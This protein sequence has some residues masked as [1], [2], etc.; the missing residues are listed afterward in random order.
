L[1]KKLRTKL[2]IHVDSSFVGVMSNGTSGDVTNQNFELPNPSLNLYQ[3]SAFVSED[4]ATRIV[5]VYNT[6]DF[7]D[8]VPLKAQTRELT[9][10]IRQPTQ[11]ILDHVELIK[12]FHLTAPPGTYLFEFREEQYVTRLEDY[13]NTFPASISVPLQAFSFGDLAIGAIPFEVFAETGLEL[14]EAIP[15]DDSFI[16]GLANGHWGYLPTPAQ[17][18]KG[19]YEAWITA[20]RVAEN[21]SEL[22]VDEMLDLFDTLN[23]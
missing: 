18:L 11:E 14:K 22:I 5:D 6:L 10:Q 15:S 23:Q 3:R 9:L 7:Y 21:S 8:W 20:N 12:T 19:G 13:M 1:A 17:H 16:I 2:A 4:L